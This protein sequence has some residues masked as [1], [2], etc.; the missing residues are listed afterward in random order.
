MAGDTALTEYAGRK[1]R[2]ATLPV[3][4]E[5]Q[6]YLLNALPGHLGSVQGQH[7][8]ARTGGRFAGRIPTNLPY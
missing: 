5:E 8:I 3:T 1:G 6:Q 2:M 7:W 4:W